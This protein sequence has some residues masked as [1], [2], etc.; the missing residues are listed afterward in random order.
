MA[1]TRELQVGLSGA[2]NIVVEQIVQEAIK[3]IL[4]IE[5]QTS[6]EQQIVQGIIARLK[7]DTTFCGMGRQEQSAVFAKAIEECQQRYS[8]LDFTPWT[9]GQSQVYQEAMRELL[10]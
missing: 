5:L 8:H 4:R 2:D 9:L 7:A 10:K 6:K 3:G 1:A